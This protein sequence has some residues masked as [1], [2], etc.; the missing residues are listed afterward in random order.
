MARI[1]VIEEAQATG[2]IKAIYE[3]IQQKLG[4]VSNMD[5]LLHVLNSM[6]SP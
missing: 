2:N 6:Y 1:Q 3:G 5:P 4:F